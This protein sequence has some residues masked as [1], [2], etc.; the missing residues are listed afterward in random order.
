MSLLVKESACSYVVFFFLCQRKNCANSCFYSMMRALVAFAN[1]FKLTFRLFS[2]NLFNR[3]LILCSLTIFFLFDIR[4]TLNRLCKYSLKHKTS[5]SKMNLKFNENTSLHQLV[6]FAVR[7]TI[8]NKKKINFI[9][10]QMNF[11]SKNIQH[12]NK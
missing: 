3:Y 9:I 12:P 6:L 4:A 2:A 10:K 11:F 8:I 5:L 7:Q 1:L